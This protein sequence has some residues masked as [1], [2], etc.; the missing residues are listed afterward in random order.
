MRQ[1]DTRLSAHTGTLTLTNT[2]AHIH[3]NL[4]SLAAKLTL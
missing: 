2:H 4:H 1:I 3:T